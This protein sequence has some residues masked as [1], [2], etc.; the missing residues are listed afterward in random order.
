[1]EWMELLELVANVVVQAGLE[2][3]GHLDSKDTLDHLDQEVRLV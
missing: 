1:M 3:Q 2:I